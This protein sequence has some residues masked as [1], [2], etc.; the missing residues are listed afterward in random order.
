MTF[1]SS[2]YQVHNST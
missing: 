1:I 2:N